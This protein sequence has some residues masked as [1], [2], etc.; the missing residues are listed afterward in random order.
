MKQFDEI[1]SFETIPFYQ[2]ETDFLVS[3]LQRFSLNDLQA[4]LKANAEITIDAYQ[5]Y[6]TFDE[7]PTTM[8]IYAYDGIQY[9][10]MNLL[11]ISDYSFKYLSQ[12]LL[13]IS[14]LYGILRPC[15][16]IKPYRLEMQTK[17]SFANYQNL[18]DYWFFNIT[19]KPL[20]IDRDEIIINLASNEYSKLFRKCYPNHTLINIFFYEKTPKGLKELGIYAKIAR[21]TMVRYLADQQITNL[22]EIKQFSLLNYHFSVEHSNSTNFIF[23]REEKY[24]KN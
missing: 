10:S 17:F 16:L 5:K 21:G 12:N 1:R 14:G 18:Y 22:E 8:A 15:D 24:V 2:D 19:E 6:Q 7:L 13:I 9:S 20:L 3:H 4:I 23:I 11:S